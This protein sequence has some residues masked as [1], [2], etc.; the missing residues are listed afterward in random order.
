[1]ESERDLRME[2]FLQGTL[3]SLAEESHPTHKCIILWVLSN[4]G[5][6]RNINEN[7][8]LRG[9]INSRVE[10]KKVEEN[11]IEFRAT[12]NRAELSVLTFLDVCFKGKLHCAESAM[13]VKLCF[14]YSLLYTQEKMWKT[15]LMQLVR[16]VVYAL[17]GNY[18]SVEWLV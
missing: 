12:P 14:A 16:M 5:S 13:R 8:W 17:W 3:I 15:P 9:R 18:G 7:D 2:V 10:S 1:M 6:L 4:V 11:I